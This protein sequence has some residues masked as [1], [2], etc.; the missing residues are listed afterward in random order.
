[1]VAL[2]DV[3]GLHAHY[4]KSH[5]LHG[6]SLTIAPGEIVSL[7]GRNGSGRSTT[8]K[9][10]MGLVRRPAGGSCSGSRS[11]GRACL[12]HCPLRYRLRAGRA[13]DLRQHHRRREYA[14]RH[15]AAAQRRAAWTRWPDVRF[16]PAAERAL[17]HCCGNAVGRR[18]ADADNVP[19]L[20]GN[21]VSS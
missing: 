5:I 19:A 1:M 4:D 13:R 16:F 6:V 15:A 7:L 14:H 21:P 18:A 8:L 17:Q 9:T 10:I 12:P 20:L 11:C 2:L 3:E